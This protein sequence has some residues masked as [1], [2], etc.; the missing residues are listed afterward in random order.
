VKVAVTAVS[1]FSVTVQVEVPLHPPPLQPAK[2]ESP[3]ATGVS[4][5][6]VPLT[7]ELEQ[8]RPQNIPKPVTVPLPV[9]AFDTDSV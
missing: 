1:A 8:D 9:P 4:V 6:M 3:V 5:T 7:K 2:I